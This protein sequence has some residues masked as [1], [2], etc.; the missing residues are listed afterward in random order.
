MNSSK[1][2]SFDKALRLCS[3]TEIAELFNNGSVFF[4][5]PFRI[6]FL[7]NNYHTNQYLA[8]VSKRKFRK[9]VDRNRIKRLIREGIRLHFEH[10][11]EN[12]VNIILQYTAKSIE[13]FY[14]IEK[15]IHA[16]QKHFKT[17]SNS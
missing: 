8:T 16:I 4:V 7:K 13:P 10:S 17:H 15:G 11:S 12:N 14:K 5:Y 6:I 1:N 2:N 3:K 9:A